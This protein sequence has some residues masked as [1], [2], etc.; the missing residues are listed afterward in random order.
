MKLRKEALRQNTFFR[1]FLIPYLFI[2]ILPL[3]LAG[4]AYNEAMRIVERE[5][6]QSKLIV[7]EQARD[8]V[9]SYFNDLDETFI[10]L[11]IDPKLSGL[12][13][14]EAPFGNSPL[15]FDVWDYLN[16]I[17]SRAVASSSLQSSFFIALRDGDLVL[18]SDQ[19]VQSGKPFYEDAFRYEDMSY[20]EWRDRL[21]GRRYM[22]TVFPAAKA[23]VAGKERSVISYMSSLPIHPADAN[24]SVVSFLIDVEDIGR[25][26][27]SKGS[28]G[29]RFAILDGGGRYIMGGDG[30]YFDKRKAP[31]FDYADE[32]HHP[33]V[34][35]N[36]ENVMYVHTR[37]SYNDWTY[38]SALPLE[39]VMGDVIRI[40]NVAVAAAALSLLVG[41]LFSV[42]FAY[43]G[44]KPLREMIGTLK[45]FW[46][47]TKADELPAVR[48][49]AD[50][51]S[52]LRGSIAHLISDHQH[53][54]STLEYRNAALKNVFFDRLLKG[55]FGN[56]A[57]MEELKADV[58]PILDG[59][60]FAV[61]L[62]QRYRHPASLHP[63]ALEEL[64][65]LREYAEAAI[66]QSFPG[67][68]H[69]HIASENELAVLLGS[70]ERDDAA[71]SGKIRALLER[72]IADIR[73]RGGTT[74]IVG[75]GGIYPGLPD[76]SYSFQEA[77][78]ALG[79]QLAE[80]PDAPP[81]VW[82]EEIKKEYTGYYFPTEMEIKLMNIV[83]S[84]AVGEDRRILDHLRHEN[85][86]VRALTPD[87]MQCL[88]N[89]LNATLY[90]L[91]DQIKSGPEK[92]EPSPP[93]PLPAG[94]NSFEA[95][96]SRFEQLCRSVEAGK[97]SRNTRL[98]QAIC[99]YIGETFTD[100]NLSLSGV[101]SRF[102]MSESYLSQFFRE[103]TDETFSTYVE[104]LRIGL[105]RRLIREDCDSI[106]EIALKAGYNSTHS[107]RRA[108]KRV[109]GIVPSAYKRTGE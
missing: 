91:H 2:L 85:E 75:V 50:D 77:R 69:V 78:Q 60:A 87:M 56:Q 17:R 54:R 99:E 55:E 94:A 63:A 5:A 109:M 93:Q 4:F 72:M 8:I 21:F 79:R 65:V 84:G 35:R 51:F 97:K 80:E 86:T 28:D 53:L 95:I 18:T 31:D 30:A 49:A 102:N 46:I 14:I 26:I 27:G 96:A 59:S 20:D 100:A 89:D 40:R 74:P 38:V 15:W 62:L 68:S 57:G 98:A 34:K 88:L 6:R 92:D 81:V 25:L 71:F 36:G 32:G 58:G 33:V 107:F 104:S 83:K 108:F 37:S 3:L 43:R 101:A 22:K 73:E 41:L 67:R 45:E 61:V 7:L 39:E 11:S 106:D 42:L 76:A 16:E 52:F 44:S 29:D 82:Y 10:Q 66:G 13:R 103:Q 1:R 19:T 90:K 48:G 23:I 12:M 70:A 24:L 105:A 64:D 9:D 47:R